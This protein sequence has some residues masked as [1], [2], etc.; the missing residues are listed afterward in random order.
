M[1]Y[2]GQKVVCINAQDTDAEN[3]KEL[4]KGAIYTIRWS[5]VWGYKGVLKP[6]PCVRLLGIERI[7]P[8]VVGMGDVPF[9][10]SRFRPITEHKTDISVFKA[11]LNPT[12]AKVLDHVVSD[13][14]A[15]IYLS[16][17]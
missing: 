8:R 17:L 6:R 13:T 3:E 12:P 11:L 5:G 16:S 1:F 9:R 2:V 10:A 14:L 15:K 7:E 4:S